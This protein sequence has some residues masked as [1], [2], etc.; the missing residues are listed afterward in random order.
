MT[1]SLQPSRRLHT[2]TPAAANFNDHHYSGMTITPDRV[3]EGLQLDSREVCPFLN[4]VK[5]TL[6][7]DAA[8]QAAIAQGGIDGSQALRGVIAGCL[9]DVLDRLKSEGRYREFR[10]LKRSVGNHPEVL[11]QLGDGGASVPVVNW[12][13]NDYLNMAH[14]PAVL[15]AMQTTLQEQGAGAGG[16]RNI[17]GSNVLHIELEQELA[18]L[19]QT[20]ASLLFQSCYTANLGK[21]KLSCWCWRAH[22]MCCEQVLWKP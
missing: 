18:A 10:Y 2:C 12:C 22:N 7:Q 9:N 13:S 20:E 15:A 5:T 8:A 16:T 19:C 21:N 6:Q 4:E 3:E 14:H 17:A 1:A 11:W